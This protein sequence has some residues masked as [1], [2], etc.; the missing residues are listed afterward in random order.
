MGA[1]VHLAERRLSAAAAA[2]EG[3]A[4][5]APMP[6]PHLD[7]VAAL[8]FPFLYLFLS[9][10]LAGRS[11]SPLVPRD[12]TRSRVSSVCSSMNLPPAQGSSL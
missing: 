12:L 7:V 4:I 1:E 11:S 2:G 3:V 6:T 5:L 10:E 9:S 8:L